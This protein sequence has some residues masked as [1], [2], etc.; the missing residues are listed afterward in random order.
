MA[1]AAHHREVLVAK[2]RGIGQPG[3]VYGGAAR[4]VLRRVDGNAPALVAPDAERNRERARVR[5]RLLLPGRERVVARARERPVALGLIA[6]VE[7]F[8]RPERA[9]AAHLAGEHRKAAARAASAPAHREAVAV[10]HRSRVDL[11]GL[12]PLAGHDYLA[13]RGFGEALG[14]IEGRRAVDQRA[15]RVTSSEQQEP[16]HEASRG[17]SRSAMAAVR[18]VVEWGRLRGS[19]AVVNQGDCLVGW[20]DDGFRTHTLR[21]EPQPEKQDRNNPTKKQSTRYDQ[22]AGTS[23]QERSGGRFLSQPHGTSRTAATRSAPT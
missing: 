23:P 1:P 8:D 12:S 11:Q 7:L 22:L 18:P 3:C 6:H 19:Q 17:R 20:V 21:L 14:G 10:E 4:L 5:R 13:E 2:A 16:E 15:V 9:V